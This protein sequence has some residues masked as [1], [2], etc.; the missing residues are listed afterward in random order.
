MCPANAA[1]RRNSF[2]QMLP[3]RHEFWLLIHK[4]T[5]T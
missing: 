4:F 2:T 1:A 3:W 5:F